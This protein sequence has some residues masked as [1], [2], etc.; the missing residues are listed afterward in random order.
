MDSSS[1]TRRQTLYRRILLCAT[2]ALL[3]TSA[4]A[5]GGQRDQ[6]GNPTQTLT[7]P[8]PAPYQ[9]GKRKG[10]RAIAVVRWDADSKD[11]A[12]PVLMPVAILDDGKFYDAGIYKAAPSPMPLLVG[13]VYEAQDHGEILGYFTI[14][15][16]S[17]N[18]RKD[19]W[20]ALGDWQSATPPMDKFDPKAVSHVEVVT[21]KPGDQPEATGGDNND[22]RDLNKK[23]TTVYDENGKAMPEGTTAS[24]AAP[25]GGT[26]D[27]RPTLKR[28]PGSSSKADKPADT[29]T[30]PADKKTAD[31]PDRP[32]MKRESTPATAPSKPTAPSGSDTSSTTTTTAN[33][34][35]DTTVPADKDPD[36]PEL[37]RGK[38]V[39][40]T[41]EGGLP[42]KVDTRADKD[43][44]I[45]RRNSGTNT[46]PKKEP[47]QPVPDRVL[48]RGP[49]LGETGSDT[50][51]LRRT[52]TYEAAAVSDANVDPPTNFRFKM[53][54]DE[55]E[56]LQAKMDA[57][58]QDEVDAYLKKIGRPRPG[59]AV[60][61]SPRAKT[62]ARRGAT[63]A[64]AKEVP[65]RKSLFA[66]S[67]FEVMD[68]DH[69]NDATLIFS[70][71][72]RLEPKDDATTS[73]PQDVYVVYVAHVDYQ[74]NPRGIFRSVTVNDRLDVTP[75]LELIDAID[76]QGNGMGQLLFRRVNDDGAQF[77]I[78]KVSF[79][80]MTEI[81]HG[82]TA[83]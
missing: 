83:D 13:T 20:L 32:T 11:H 40:K 74:G 39:T 51:T 60:A 58:A 77:A 38:P 4:A 22:D 34:S 75:R 65:A 8:A 55:R 1:K 24:P 79:D 17:H 80:G 62:P 42:Q 35:A 63:S 5:Q 7:P 30:K 27:S 71:R 48:A 33:K 73:T 61:A 29:S 47:T 67:Q 21:G 15:A 43:R 10:P 12:V 57:L 31:D 41:V 45:I 70:G 56:A 9:Y 66:E 50:P 59:A 2:C 18:E 76:A 78:Y 23:K 69:R 46:D 28:A 81:F 26:G 6:R 36:R 49:L 82:G 52:R 16:Q 72:E 3:V 64:K 54:T 25:M 19:Y 37:K 68:L 44:P 53:S 14:K